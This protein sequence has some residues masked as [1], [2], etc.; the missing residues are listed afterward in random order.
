MDN[1]YEVVVTTRYCF[2]LFS[3]VG[4]DLKMSVY[5]VIL[6]CTVKLVDF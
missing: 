2:V 4:H 5:F 1:S 3:A 6:Y